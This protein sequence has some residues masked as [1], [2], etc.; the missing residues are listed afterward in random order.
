MNQKNDKWDELLVKTCGLT[1]PGMVKSL[2]SI[3][4]CETL[5]A[6]IS[7]ANGNF[8]KANKP[9]NGLKIFKDRRQDNS[10]NERFV[11]DPPHDN[12]ALTTWYKRFFQ[13]EAFGLIMN[14]L[15]VYENEIVEE[16][17]IHVAPLLEKRG[18]PWAGLSTLFF[19][20]DY[21]YTPFGVHRDSPGEDGILFHLGPATKIF[22]IWETDVYNKLT[23]HA[24]SYHNVEEILHAATPY[25]LEPGDAISFPDDMYHVANTEEFSVSLVLDY[26]RGA[27]NTI[28][29]RLIK[30]MLKVNIENNSLLEHVDESELLSALDFQKESE[31]AVTRLKL[32]LGS[33][34]GF[35][36]KSR[37]TPFTIDLAGTY[38]LKAPF[39]LNVI[40]QQE[41]KVLVFS[42]GHEIFTRQS[43]F[44]VEVIE[45]L[46]S[47]ES[48]N[49]PTLNIEFVPDSPSMTVFEFIIKLG[50]TDVLEKV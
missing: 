25:I 11:N 27:K 28:K 16:M 33:N 48:L 6:L 39:R 36:K 5:L 21:G 32:R 37:I 44:L 43:S 1:S 10:Q 20:G 14:F 40:N 29:E 22:Y 50:E 49:L 31:A 35:D 41:N 34:G 38:K 4:E 15:E 13:G 45:S 42:R 47:G 12:E 23:N 19:M 2:L 3:K 18:T 24:E 9:F 46:N 17:A 26:R 8:A 30:E 7:K